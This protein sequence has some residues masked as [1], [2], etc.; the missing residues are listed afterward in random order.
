M[1]TFLPPRS[2]HRASWP[3]WN[4]PAR[5][6][7]HFPALS[8]GAADNWLRET[9]LPP[10]RVVDLLPS[11][12]LARRPAILRR[13]RTPAPKSTPNWK[14]IILVSPDW[15]DNLTVPQHDELPEDSEPLRSDTCTS[16]RWVW[17]LWRD[18]DGHWYFLKVWSQ[19]EADPENPDTPGAALTVMEAFQF[20]LHNWMPRDVIADLIFD[21][22]DMVRCLNLPPASPGL[23]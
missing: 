7:E 2:F 11:L 10:L 21:H 9:I 13:V 18:P 19:D 15:P 8:A 4:Y 16:E 14:E 17:E 3:D 20:L 1:V 22:P 5:K 6:E 23:N 12:A